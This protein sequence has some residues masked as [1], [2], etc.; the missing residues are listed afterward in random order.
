[1]KRSAS[2]L[3]RSGAC[4]QSA[5]RPRRRVAGAF[6]ASPASRLP[7]ARSRVLTRSRLR[8]RPAPAGRDG[9][10]AA[11]HFEAHAARRAGLGHA[12]RSPARRR[13]APAPG[14]WRRPASAARPAAPPAPAR[15]APPRST[16]ASS[17]APGSSGWPGKWPAKAGWSLRHVVRV[18]CT[19]VSSRGQLR[20]RELAQRAHRE[21]AGAFARQRRHVHHAARHEHR[22]EPLRAAPRPL[23]ARV[24]RRRHH[25]GHRPHHAVGHV[26]G[27]PEGAVLDAG[28]AVEV[29]VQVAERAALAGDVD[30][31]VGAAQQAEAP[32]RRAAPARRPS[33]S[34]RA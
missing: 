20:Q 7:S 29:V 24:E 21:L 1:M 26:V 25:E 13:G 34:A 27:Q 23:G 10:V 2:M 4:A 30:Q 3:L 6:D 11:A 17:S 16:S 15:V 32:R 8:R 28:D 31:V 5:A 18:R 14:T 12:D 9:V 19:G 33:A 22:L